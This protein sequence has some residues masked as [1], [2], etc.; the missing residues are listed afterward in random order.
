MVP[1][2]DTRMITRRFA[3]GVPKC[4]PRM[5]SQAPPMAATVRGETD[6]I[7]GAAWHSEG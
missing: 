6:S 4:V 7:T 1:L 3:A 5:V 2:L